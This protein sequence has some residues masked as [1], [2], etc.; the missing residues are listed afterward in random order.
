[1][2]PL[3]DQARRVLEQF[4][5]AAGMTD[6]EQARLLEALQQRVHRGDLP[7]F[8][9]DASLP[10]AARK[11]ALGRLSAWST[12]KLVL[13]A[14]VVAATAW[15]GYAHWLAKQPV[16]AAKASAPALLATSPLAIGFSIAPPPLSLPSASSATEAPP[17]IRPKRALPEATIDEEVRLLNAAQA[18]LRAGNP[19]RTLTLLAEHRVR[20]PSGK[21]KDARDVT[22]MIALAQTGRTDQACAEARRFV[23]RDPATPF[24]DRLKAICP[25]LGEAP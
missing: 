3:S 23:A 22:R 25:K 4:R 7:R 15:G 13:I 18:A 2:K 21:L 5:S 9:V 1:M 6:E 8:A 20:F 11:R 16:S 19:G 24:T 10:T 17:A 14:A 12:S